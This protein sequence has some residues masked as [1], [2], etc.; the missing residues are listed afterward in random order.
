MRFASSTAE[1]SNEPHLIMFRDGTWHL[2]PAC[3]D[4]L[5]WL[6]LLPAERANLLT[7]DRHIQPQTFLP[8]ILHPPSLRDFYAFEAHV[9]NARRS[10]G[11]EM[12]QEWY[13]IPAFYFSNPGCLIGH[14]HPVTI[15]PD[16][17][18]LDYELELAAVIGSEGINLSLQEAEAYIAGFTLMNDW[19]ARDIQRLEMRIGLGPAKSK[20][21]A[22]SLGPW[23]VTVDELEPWRIP[24]AERGSRWRV[25]VCARVNGQEISRG[26]MA[27]MYWTFAEIIAH[28]SR[29]ARL[30][31][32]DIIGSGT[33]G[34]GCIVE[35]PEGTY[36]WLQ[37]GDTVELEA[38]GIGILRNSIMEG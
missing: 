11:L 8:P 12:L 20:D 34:T 13:Q 1:G 32:G 33:V 36:P 4:Y 5:D 29:N 38:E 26:N 27:E 15:P 9:R 37:P 10:R 7:I 2:V 30:L 18:K 3:Q 22:T 23:I 35:F 25:G 6:R 17:E 21:F 19:S 16:T 31:P 24:D 28:A 14:D